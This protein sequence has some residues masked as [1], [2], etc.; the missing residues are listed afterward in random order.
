[1]RQGILQQK[2]LKNNP[3]FLYLYT[4]I[5]RIQGITDEGNDIIHF[6]ASNF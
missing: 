3:S 1:M 4:G 2:L 6:S 5:F